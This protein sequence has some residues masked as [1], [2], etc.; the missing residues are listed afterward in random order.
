LIWTV[1]AEGFAVSIIGKLF[2]WI[3]NKNLDTAVPLL[4]AEMGASKS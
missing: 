3:Y 2:A 4:I 1:G